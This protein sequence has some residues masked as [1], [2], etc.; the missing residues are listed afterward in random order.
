[1]NFKLNKSYSIKEDGPPPFDSMNKKSLEQDL[2]YLR[3]TSG[4]DVQ[5]DEFGFV[6]SSKG[7]GANKRRFDDYN[8][9][10]YF[11]TGVQYGRIVENG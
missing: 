9:A 5:Y 4:L 1:M 3:R 2:E 7:V 6:F 11:A 8:D 10:Y